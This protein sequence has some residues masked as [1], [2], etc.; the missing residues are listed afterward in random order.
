M[1]K[2]LRTVT[3]IN[4]INQKV[5]LKIDNCQHCPMMKFHQQSCIATCRLFESEQGNIIDDFVLDYNVNSGK[6][7]GDIKIPTWCRLAE[8][9]S[10]LDFDNKTY[11]I[12]NDKVLSSD[13]IVD[14]NL[15]VH[16]ASEVKENEELDI[17]E[18]L[19]ALVTA[20]VFKNSNTRELT[21]DEAYEQAYLEYENYGGNYSFNKR[22]PPVSK[23]GICSL[24][25]EEDDTVNR[26]TNHGMCDGCWEVSFDNDDRKKQAFINN[27]RMK[28]GEPFKLETFN[29]SVLKTD[30]LKVLITK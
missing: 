5:I 24:C 6:V 1:S 22:T 16:V 17:M 7:H 25:G 19:P 20:S 27:F 14:S 2:Y 12:H 18:L 28:R 13:A 29:L 21:P 4:G 23:H 11:T 15:P 30:S 9:E 8:L 26:N 10:Q 3:K